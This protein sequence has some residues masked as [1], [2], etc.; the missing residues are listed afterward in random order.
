M[1]CESKIK[2]TLRWEKFDGALSR[3]LQELLNDR[4]LVDVTLACQGEYIKAHKNVLSVCSP[5]FK[6]LFKVNLILS[7]YTM[8]MLTVILYAVREHQFTQDISNHII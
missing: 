5:Y 6:T 1:S 8:R 3:G 2:M 7:E 4:D